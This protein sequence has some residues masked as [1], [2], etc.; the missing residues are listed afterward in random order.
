MMIVWHVIQVVLPGHNTSY[1]T[2]NNWIESHDDENAAVRRASVMNE[3]RSQQCCGVEY[4][5]AG[6]AEETEEQDFNA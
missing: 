4:T 1:K 2:G 5:V 3:C 6:P